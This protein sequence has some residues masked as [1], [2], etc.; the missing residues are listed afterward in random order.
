MLTR[1]APMRAVAYWSSV[2]SAQFGAQIPMR[3]PAAMP[4]ASSPLARAST[5]V[6]SSP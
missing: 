6:S 3:S 1:I 4:F 2:H 5:S